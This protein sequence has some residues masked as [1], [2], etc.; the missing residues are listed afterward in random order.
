MGLAFVDWA[1]E[2]YRTWRTGKSKEQREWEAWY[3]ANVIY[4]A[5]DITNM[6][7][8]FKHIIL[9]DVDKFVDHSEPLV[10]VPCKDAKQYFWPQR[11]LG[12]NAVWRFER[13][14]WD[15]WDQRWHVNELAGDDHI[16]VATNNDDDALLI[17]LKF[18]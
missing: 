6:F 5:N 1:S 8:H 7:M 9:V 2:K 18:T 15:E 12:N 17:T 10:W 14:I 16:F 4:C 11:E 13:V 3:E